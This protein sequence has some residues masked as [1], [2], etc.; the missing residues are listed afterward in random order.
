[1][2]LTLR[3]S[4]LV[5]QLSGLTRRKTHTVHIHIHARSHVSTYK[6][7][8][9]IYV[10]MN[11]QG[12]HNVRNGIAWV[13]TGHSTCTLTTPKIRIVQRKKFRDDEKSS[14]NLLIAS[15][16][17]RNRSNLFPARMVTHSTGHVYACNCPL[18][19]DA[20]VSLHGM[21]RSVGCVHTGSFRD[22]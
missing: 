6:Y 11:H 14:S 2:Y 7:I 9:I 20:S 10:I 3:F 21:A 4:G 19:S 16:N 12:H 5:H 17:P 1:M 22:R 13:Q 15:E 8:D 18:R